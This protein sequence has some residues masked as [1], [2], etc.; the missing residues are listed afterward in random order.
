MEWLEVAKVYTELGILGLVGVL[1]IVI[2]YQ[3]FK[4]NSQKDD[5]K[6]KRID[7]KDDT[8]VQDKHNLEN[9]FNEMIELIQQQN[10][11][12]QDQQ[13]KNTELLIQSVIQGVTN[14][15]PS[16][17]EN[18]KLTKISEEIDKHL[19][20]ILLQT[21]ASRANLVQYHNRWKRYK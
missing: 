9:K 17:E 4:R 14:H 21:N 11:E 13:A 18:D 6:D 8:Y 2:M 15:V 3:S 5:E 10:Q 1:F 12:Y 16:P 20:Q 19:Q 7:K